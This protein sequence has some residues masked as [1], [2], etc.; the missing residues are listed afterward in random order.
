MDPVTVVTVPVGPDVGL[1]LIDAAGVTV[2]AAVELAVPLVA[3]TVACPVPD[4]GTANVAV[5][6]PAGLDVTVVGFV[7]SAVPLNVSE[8]VELAG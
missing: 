6:A 8:T 5:K 4:E 7:V 3:R 1:R 2:N